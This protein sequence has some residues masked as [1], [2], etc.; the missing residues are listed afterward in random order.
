[1]G[2]EKI[3]IYMKEKGITLS[4]LSERS[5]IPLGTLNKIVYGIT[6]NPSLDNMRKIAHSL[7]KTL[8][9]FVDSAAQG[10]YLNPETAQIAQELYDNPDMRILL[11]ASRKATP[12]E[13]RKIA[14]M[15]KI[16]VREDEE[17]Q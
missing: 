2:I 8:D 15:A 6:K 9:D 1:M 13:L 12:D 11:D 17:N 10:Y 3:R 4:E 5:G 16:M 14:E 7:G